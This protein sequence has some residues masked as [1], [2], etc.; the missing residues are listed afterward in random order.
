MC[1]V[2][3]WCNDPLVNS[4]L[5]EGGK[6]KVVPV[7]N[8][9]VGGMEIKF[10]AFLILT[11]DGGECST[12]FPILFRP[13]ERDP[14]SHWIG[15]WVGP[16]PADLDTVVLGI[17]PQSSTFKRNW[18]KHGNQDISDVSSGRRGSGNVVIDLL[19]NINR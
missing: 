12:P 14:G 13:G 18:G 2:H 10:H 3:P 7:L 6:G 9:D 19:D 17:E 11:L 1:Y 16:E 8:Q 4:G 5:C 15:S